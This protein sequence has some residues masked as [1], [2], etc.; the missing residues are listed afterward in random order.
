[1]QFPFLVCL[2]CCFVLSGAAFDFVLKVVAADLFSCGAALVF[3]GF[4]LITGVNGV[5][6]RDVNNVQ[7]VLSIADHV[8]TFDALGLAFFFVKRLVLNPLFNLFRVGERVYS[9]LFDIGGSVTFFQ[10][11][12]LYSLRRI[13][14]LSRSFSVMNKGVVNAPADRESSMLLRLESRRCFYSY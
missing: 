8:E 11:W 5:E 13:G 3:P 7:L 12:L 9:A 10:I 4:D 14:A 6:E 2:Q 1:M